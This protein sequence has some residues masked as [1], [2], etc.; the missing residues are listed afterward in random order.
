MCG[1]RICNIVPLIVRLNSTYCIID[2]LI[3]IDSPPM[4]C[5]IYLPTIMR[6]DYVLFQDLFYKSFVFRAL[7]TTNNACEMMHTCDFL[8]IIFVEMPIFL[9]N[10][11]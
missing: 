3:I 11:K 5:D 4:N 7:E 9:N 1:I 10:N 8:I 6:R 2:L